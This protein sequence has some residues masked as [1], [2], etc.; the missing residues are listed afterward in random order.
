MREPSK[1]I[2]RIYNRW[3]HLLQEEDTAETL[4]KHHSWD[5]EIE[6]EPGKEPT[7]GPI[8]ALSEKKLATLREYLGDNEKKGFIKKVQ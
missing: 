7:F 5:H 4:P 1:H 8:Y 6:L 2:L 3:E